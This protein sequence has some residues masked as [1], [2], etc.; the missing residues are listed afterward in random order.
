MIKSDKVIHHQERLRR[1]KRYLNTIR[2]KFGTAAYK[3]TKH[4]IKLCD[5]VA[6]VDRRRTRRRAMIIQYGRLSY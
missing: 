2:R 4:A 6:I 5:Y 1:K 3:S